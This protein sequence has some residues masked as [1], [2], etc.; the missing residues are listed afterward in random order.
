M[1][2]CNGLIIILGSPNS[3]RGELF[4]IAKERCEQGLWESNC[5]PD[6]K[7]L[8]TGG[9][10]DHFNRSNKPH[11]YHMK[12]YLTAKGIPK[13]YFVEFAESKNTLEDASLSK[14]IVQKY[15]VKHIIVITS[16]YH[17]D[18]AQFVFE[19]EYSDVDVK[20]EYS[21]SQTNETTCDI[22]LIPIKQHEIRA[23]KILKEK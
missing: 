8:L 22:D 11:A 23:L 5:H 13:D 7:I 3:E 21:I 14:P 4:S 19:K 16:D 20:I 9:Y 12:E 15:R 1:H 6:Y 18:R 17:F 10:G 2:V